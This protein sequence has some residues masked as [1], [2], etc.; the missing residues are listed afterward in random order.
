MRSEQTC[1]VSNPPPP[2]YK[3]YFININ[4]DYFTPMKL[5]L[6]IDNQYSM[7]VNNRFDKS[8]V[9][10][11]EWISRVPQTRAAHP[12]GD[13]ELSAWTGD[14]YVNNV[15]FKLSK[16]AEADLFYACSTVGRN[17]QLC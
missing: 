2:Q 12:E 13:H 14:K 11:G 5:G 6:S 3:E 1:C 4:K 9:L 8:N 7:I 16:L 17:R 15:V 10:H